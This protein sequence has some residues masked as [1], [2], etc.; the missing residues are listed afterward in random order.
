MQ[1]FMLP[2]LDSHRRQT[3]QVCPLY[4]R[5]E[6]TEVKKGHMIC[7]P[8]VGLFTSGIAMSHLDTPPGS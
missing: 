3:F 7:L 5:D 2:E 1:K 8:K 4:Y 6:Q